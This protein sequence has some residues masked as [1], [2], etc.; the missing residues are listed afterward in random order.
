MRARA[1]DEEV[2]RDLT[3]LSRKRILFGHQSVGANILAGVQDLT[4]GSSPQ[5]RVVEMKSATDLTPGTLA[6]VFVAENGHPLKKLASFERAL[7]EAGTAPDIALM[8]FC[9][10]DVSSKTDVNAL[11]ARY[12]ETMGRLRARYPKTIFVHVTM[13]LTIVQHGAKAWVKDLM[14]R[15]TGVAENARR[16][17]FNA[18]LRRTYDGKE[19]I[20]DLARI[21]STR[22]DGSA[23][24]SKWNGQDVPGLVSAYA[25]DSGHLNERGRVVAARGLIGVLAAL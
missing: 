7:A 14:G 19:P 20:F 17:D 16:E 1:A 3:R 8:K 21:E 22:P 5:L 9:Y 10:V 13:P 23:E 4:V 11:F 24:V 6:H 18:R 25:S 15:S 2:T 12:E